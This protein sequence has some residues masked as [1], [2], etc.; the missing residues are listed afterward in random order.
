M[1]R[2]PIKVTEMEIDGHRYAAEYFEAQTLRGV[3][4]YSCEVMLD[5]RDRIILDDDSLSGLESKVTCMVPAM[6]YSRVLAGR[7]PV[8][9]KVNAA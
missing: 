6:I 2:R 3:K 4:R 9:L 1:F 7:P 8:A 5:S